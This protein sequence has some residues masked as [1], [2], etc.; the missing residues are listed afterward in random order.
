MCVNT[1]IYYCL[2]QCGTYYAKCKNADKFGSEQLNLRATC[3]STTASL[4]WC[5]KIAFSHRSS[6]TS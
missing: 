2:L 5:R 6:W 4:F 3:Y 1:G